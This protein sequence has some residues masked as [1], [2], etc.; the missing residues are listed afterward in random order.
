M[1]LIAS[2]T[3]TEWICLWME[4]VCFVVGRIAGRKV[5]TT[6]TLVKFCLHR[7]SKLFL[8]GKVLF[9]M[10]T[11]FSEFLS[12]Q[13]VAICSTVFWMVCGLVI[14]ESAILVAHTGTV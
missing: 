6:R 10:C 8:I 14:F 9:F 1:L 12:L 7:I 13:P 5:L 11:C 4:R 2:W 3:A